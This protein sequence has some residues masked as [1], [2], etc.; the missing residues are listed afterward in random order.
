MKKKVVYTKLKNLKEGDCFKTLVTGMKGMVLDIGNMSAKVLFY[1]VPDIDHYDEDEILRYQRYWLG[2]K[3]IS[4]GT[5]VQKIRSKKY[6]KDVGN[7]THSKNK[8][9]RNKRT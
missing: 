7:R 2:R 5:E 4:S 9:R 1:E 3:E 8:R 6:G